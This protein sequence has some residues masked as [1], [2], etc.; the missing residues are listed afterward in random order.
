[1]CLVHEELIGQSP[2]KL[3]YKEIKVVVVSLKG[4]LG[5]GVGVRVG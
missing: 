2:L 4:G 3:E 1:M 5:E